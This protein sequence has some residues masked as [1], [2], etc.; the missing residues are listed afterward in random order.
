VTGT[1]HSD[2]ALE[3]GSELTGERIQHMD[4]LDDR[5]NHITY[6][7]PAHPGS[8]EAGKSSDR[9]EHPPTWR[10]AEGEES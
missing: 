1:H 5:R 8:R 7:M 10:Y 6:M 3:T 2:Q 4:R 9:Q